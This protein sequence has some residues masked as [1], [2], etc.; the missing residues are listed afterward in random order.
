VRAVH[1]A[2]ENKWI[3]KQLIIVVIIIVI[4]VIA[5]VVLFVRPAGVIVVGAGAQAAVL[6]AHCSVKAQPASSA[7]L[8]GR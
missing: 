7:A 5:V 3:L 1:G 8:V 4:I 2:S 6:C